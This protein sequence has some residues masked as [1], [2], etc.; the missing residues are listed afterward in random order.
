[1]NYERTK[2]YR[3]CGWGFIALMMFGMYLIAASIAWGAEVKGPETFE[4]G[5]LVTYT[6]DIEG[7]WII[8]PAKGVG[9]A[10]DS[11][12]KNLYVAVTVP[13]DYTLIFF[14]VESGNPVI[15]QKAFT[16]QGATPSPA[17]EP[18]PNPEPEPDLKTI[19]GVTR[20]GV[21]ALDGAQKEKE[22]VAMES[23]IA[24]TVAAIDAGTVRT[25]PGAR[26]TFRQLWRERASEVSGETEVRWRELLDGVSEPMDFSSLE[27]MKAGLLEMKGALR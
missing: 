17:P 11:N 8:V 10:K 2:F 20:S 15:T 16:V 14:A 25:V 22:I 27:T 5:A 13:G 4:P 6:A 12:R 1:M 26:A 7:D 18:A 19:A 3:Q 24:D 9:A 23:A 21:A